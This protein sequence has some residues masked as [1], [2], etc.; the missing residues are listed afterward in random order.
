MRLWMIDPKL[1]CTQHLLGEHLEIHLHKHIFVKH[2]SIDGRI[3]PI[4]Q[5]EPASME[6]R[7]NELVIEM[8]R[9]GFKHNSPYVQ[10]DIS[11][12]PIDQQNAKVD[13]KYNLKDLYNRCTEC[14]EI[15]IL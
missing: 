1:L 4:V 7:H 6:S 2:Y 13:L 8:Q 9:R 11:Y 12:L 14:R 10:P 15:G 3:C 5:I